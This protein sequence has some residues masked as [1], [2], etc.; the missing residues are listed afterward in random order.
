MLILMDTSVTKGDQSAQLVHVLKG[1][2]I[3]CLLP[4]GRSPFIGGPRVP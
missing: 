3:S 2:W 1:V 4:E